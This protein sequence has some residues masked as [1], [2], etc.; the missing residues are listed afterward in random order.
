MTA[1]V[2]DT[3]PSKKAS[4]PPIYDQNGITVT[5]EDQALRAVIRLQANCSDSLSVEDLERIL[6][7]CRVSQGI[8]PERLEWLVRERP[9]DTP[10][11]VAEGRAPV[12][13]E[14]GWIDYH[15]KTPDSRA[16]VGGERG[17]GSI[18]FKQLDLIVNVDE[19]TLLATRHPPQPG[20][21]GVSVLGEEL[22]APAGRDAKLAVGRNTR[23]SD[24]GL[25]LY[26]TRAGSLVRSAGRLAIAEV[27]TVNGDVDFSTGNIDFNGSVV[28][29]GN[30]LSGFSVKAADDITVCGIVE[31]ARLQA[32]GNIFLERGVQ[33]GERA[34]LLANGDIRANF[35]QHATVEARGDIQVFGPLLHCQTLAGKSILAEGPKGVIC[36]GSAQAYTRVTATT[37]GADAYTK[38]LVQVG[39]NPR[40]VE[41][42]AKIQAEIR[43]LD[44]TLAKISGVIQRL[45]MLRTRGALSAEQ[46]RVLNEVTRAQFSAARRKKELE[47]ER[48][49]V[50]RELSTIHEAVI[51]ARGV[52]Y[53]GVT[54]QIYDRRLVVQSE[55]RS[56]LFARDEVGISTSTFV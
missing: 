20:Q 30:V 36:G 25:C 28:I 27:Y 21:P 4:L 26:S 40:L 22:P 23:L 24:D 10:V 29:T 52:V 38:T 37:L 16:S 43:E 11:V 45:K 31:A 51:G 35:I 33:G 1:P 56:A 32:G 7:S 15:V 53:P 8:L 55:I 48:E 44:G 50:E 13:G 12:A 47:A 2:P 34:E 54:I 41:R 19:G 6:A 3:S 39:N 49:E 5:L 9:L 17:D 18:D 42:Q 14:D 46:T